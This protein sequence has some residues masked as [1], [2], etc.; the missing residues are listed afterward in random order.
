MPAAALNVDNRI[1]N[2]WSSQAAPQI[3]LAA[4]LEHR[5]DG[6]EKLGKD[7]ISASAVLAPR[8]ENTFAKLQ[9]REDADDKLRNDWQQPPADLA[10]RQA[11][12]VAKLQAH[13]DVDNKLRRN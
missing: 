10:P 4:H 1:R 6:D 9:A 3:T 11:N 7:W 5:V 8:Q 2:K 13:E 12:T